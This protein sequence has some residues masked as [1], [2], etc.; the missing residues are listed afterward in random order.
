MTDIKPS[1]TIYNVEQK[2]GMLIDL[3]GV[4]KGKDRKELE[5]FNLSMINQYS[6]S[7]AAPEI[8]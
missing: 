6:M 5:S 2:K 8:T 1:N 3:G 7:T 4:A